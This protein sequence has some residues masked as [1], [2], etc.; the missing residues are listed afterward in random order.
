VLFATRHNPLLSPD[1]ITYLS[2]ADHIRSGR[3]ISDF[4]D[5]PMTVFGPLFPLLLAFGGRSL[6]WARVVG[7][8]SIAGGAVL[9]GI[10]VGRRTRHAVAVGAA[11]AFGAAEGMVRMGSVVWSE[12]PYA[13]ITLA[14]LAVLSVRPV[15][16]RTALAGGAL[17]GLGFLTR[18][19]GA[20]LLMT[21]AVMVAVAVWRDGGRRATFARLTA[22]AATSVGLSAVWIVRN[23]IVTGQPLGPRFSGGANE[24]WGT[25]LQLAL[26]GI[27]NVVAGDGWS[28]A[29]ASRIGAAIL[30]GVAGCAAI[31]IHARRAAALDTGVAVLAL[32][33]VVIPVLARQM[34]ANDI[35]LRVM[36]PIVI[37]VI[38]FAAVAAERLCTRQAMSFAAAGLLA[39]W[40]YQGVALARRWPDFA[41]GG[42]GYRPQFSP[43]LYD[44][45]AQLPADA[46]VL[47]NSPPRTWWFTGHE[48]VLMGFTKPR[49]GNSYYPLDASD[50]V[51]QAC[52]GR[53]YLAWFDGLQNAGDGPRERRPD[54]AAVVRL[55]VA[56]SVPRGTLYHLV[57]VDPSACPPP[58]TATTEQG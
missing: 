19:A 46:I 18:Y 3:G 41:P 49:A 31:A 50:T 35:E 27:A 54:L 55:E 5:E 28:P 51:R 43:E 57:A 23:L 30:I 37:P 16:T 6:M 47:T 36:S 25:T 15:S 4:T 11:L 53:A 58:P 24:S 48:P 39:W 56:A 33:S 7:A 13:A 52:T 9:M 10:V 38:Y 12:A 44:A 17:A 34:T 22:F 26:R 1:S 45:V 32:T 21:G 42:S 14:M 40:M 8:A 2:V 29:A 20:G